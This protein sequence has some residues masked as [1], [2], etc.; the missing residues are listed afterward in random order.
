VVGESGAG[1][2]NG[3]RNEVVSALRLGTDVNQSTL[4]TL[5]GGNGLLGRDLL[6][7]SLWSAISALDDF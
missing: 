1:N 2:D 3:A 4:T 5:E 6:A 7:G